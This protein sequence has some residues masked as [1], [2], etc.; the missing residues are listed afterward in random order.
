MKRTQP[1]TA[2]GTRKTSEPLQPLLLKGQTNTS[3]QLITTFFET[4]QDVIY[5]YVVIALLS[6]DAKL[7]NRKRLQAKPPEHKLNEKLFDLST[8]THFLRRFNFNLAGTDE[9]KEI[10][11]PLYNYYGS[12]PFYNSMEIENETIG[13]KTRDVL[14]VDLNELPQDESEGLSL[15]QG[16]L[17]SS[18]EYALYCRIALRPPIEDLQLCENNLRSKPQ[19]VRSYPGKRRKVA[20]HTVATSKSVET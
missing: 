9:I 20:T 6:R 4:T 2:T 7:G 10:T 13:G 17:K 1:W 8:N 14:V 5:F 12:A 16:R 3:T 18:K 15:L 19:N 11:D